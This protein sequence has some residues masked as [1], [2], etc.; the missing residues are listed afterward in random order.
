MSQLG[1]IQN[2]GGGPGSGVSNAWTLTRSG[3]QVTQR[4]YATPRTPS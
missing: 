3:R 4:I 1:L 2:T